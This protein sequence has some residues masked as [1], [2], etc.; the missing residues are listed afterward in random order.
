L[1]PEKVY[2]RR[3]HA[4]DNLIHRQQQTA[5]RLSNYR[6]STVIV[7]LTLAF[8]L[9]RTAS[10]AVS[11]P[12]V[13]VTVV[14]LA[15]LALR[16]SRVR[17]KLRFAEA[18]RE[19]NRKGAERLA[20]RWGAFPDTGAEFRDDDH[21]YASD[22]DLFGQASLFQWISSAQT[23]LGRETLADMLKHPPEAPANVAARQEALAELA[24]HLA[25]RQRFEAEG[26]LLPK[27]EQ[28]LEPLLQWAMESHGTYLRPWIRL[29]ALALPAVTIG[30]IAL[31]FAGLVHW[32]VPVLFAAIQY[33][34]LRVDGKERSRVLS[35]VYGH[36]AHL[37]TYARMIGRIEEQQFRAPWLS[38]RQG[39]LRG[40]AGQPAL[41]QIQHLSK[42]AD[43]IA[44]RENAF[45]ML[46]N[47]LL[48]WD[49]HCM[50]ALETWKHESGKHLRTWLDVVAELEALSSLA[51]IR[52]E[53]P[54][55]AMPTVVGAGA[56]E[57]GE[58][59][60]L[61]ATTMGHPLIPQNRVCN[62]FSMEGAVR[63]SVITGSNM[64]GKST[65]LRTVGTN[66]VLAYAGAPVCAGQF[67][68]SLM[69]IWT[70]MRISDN[71]EQSISSFYAE[72]LRIKRI[73]AAAKTERVC[74][75]LDEIFKGTNSHD[76]HQ[77]AKALI[78]QLERD[79]AFGLISTHDLELGDLERESRGRVRN[80]HFREYY[81]GQAIKF[82][83]TLRPGISTTRNALYLIKLAGIE[84]DDK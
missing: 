33:I 42:I 30:M 59:D 19:I 35:M 46:L 48:L 39:R 9:Y 40:V 13:A 32:Q 78:A 16:H 12:A 38:E 41:R 24:S 58:P 75:L 47:I 22:L 76:R 44:N 52:F 74:F 54:D 17:E 5:N 27:R 67:R 51:H 45:F 26:L 7:G 62:D 1:A 83:Y 31:Y 8:S 79:G 71:L 61:S 55:W 82:D 64:S 77:G 50:I 57:P 81:E 18:L 66:L 23:A 4:Y 36:E 80:Y 11:L 20:G 37:R 25:W 49:Y 84:L 70:S 68:C 15:Y 73:V 14:V 65:F 28:P 60:G 69:R 56:R 21:P 72:I 53:H 2:D 3:I 6:L 63:I 10:V 34:L 29:G 43:R